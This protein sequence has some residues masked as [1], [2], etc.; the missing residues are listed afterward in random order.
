MDRRDNFGYQVLIQ[1]MKRKDETI[2]RDSDVFRCRSCC[3]S[4]TERSETSSRTFLIGEQPNAWELIH[5][6][7]KMSRHRG[8]EPGRR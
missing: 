6:R 1:L 3:V 5:P 4:A 7:A 2:R 8:A